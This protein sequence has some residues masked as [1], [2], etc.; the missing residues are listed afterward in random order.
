MKN[1]Y[2]LT[3]SMVLLLLLLLL[4]FLFCLFFFQTT[5]VHFEVLHET[6]TFS[7]PP[8]SLCI[9]PAYTQ[10]FICDR[11]TDVNFLVY[12]L[13]NRFPLPCNFSRHIVIFICIVFFFFFIFRYYRTSCR[14][15]SLF[16]CKSWTDAWYIQ[17]AGTAT[18]LHVWFIYSFHLL[19]NCSRVLYVSD[20]D[21]NGCSS[22]SWQS[23][24]L[25]TFF[26]PFRPNH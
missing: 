3:S 17:T 21:T 19:D 4:L 7:F 9:I 15:L 8:F 13:A 11:I 2:W 25:C 6:F 20:T 24:F 10:T 22:F 18:L 26:V 14:P 16:S 1:V 12:H 5:N 23:W